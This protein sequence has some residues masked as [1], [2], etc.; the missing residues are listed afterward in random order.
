MQTVGKRCLVVSMPLRTSDQT[1]QAPSL[2][3]EDNLALAS[4]DGPNISVVT[5][6][7]KSAFPSSSLPAAT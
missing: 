7:L 1:I 4:V 2:A 6:A 5:V 3:F